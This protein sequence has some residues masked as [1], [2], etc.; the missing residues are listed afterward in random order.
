M[1]LPHRTAVQ[2]ARAARKARQL[3]P[4]AIGEALG[5][6]LETGWD[7]HQLFGPTSL[8]VRLLADIE[9]LPDPAMEERPRLGSGTYL[10]ELRITPVH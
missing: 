3:F 1:T 7:L 9:A 5:R 2:Y 4:G 8:C 6:E 10:P